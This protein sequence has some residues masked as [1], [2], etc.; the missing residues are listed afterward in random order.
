MKYKNKKKDLNKNQL[1]FL[2]EIIENLKKN[3]ENV[4]KKICDL[5][6]NEYPNVNRLSSKNLMRKYHGNLINF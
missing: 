2:T 6:Y 3:K 4:L 5:F 1:N